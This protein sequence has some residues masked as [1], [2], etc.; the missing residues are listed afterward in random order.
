MSGIFV[1]IGAPGLLEFP[2]LYVG[3]ERKDPHDDGGGWMSS[4]QD[5]KKFSV[6]VDSL[7]VVTEENIIVLFY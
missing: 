4:C 6:G 3:G 7:L 5:N 1:V 2:S